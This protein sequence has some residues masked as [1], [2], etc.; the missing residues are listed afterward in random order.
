MA[1]TK[2]FISGTSYSNLPTPNSISSGPS[3]PGS[4]VVANDTDVDIN[5]SDGIGTAWSFS[6]TGMT[7]P[8]DT[9]QTTAYEPKYKVYT[10]LLT[11]SG[12]PNP[13]TITSGP[14]TI[15][16]TYEITNY[17]PGDDFTNVGASSNAN[18]IKYVATRD[19]PSVWTNSTELSYNTGVPV[20]TVLE[21]TIGNV[22]FGYDGVGSY[23]VFSPEG[24][25]LE[26]KTFAISTPNSISSGIQN[27]YITTL[28]RYTDNA[29]L[30][31]SKTQNLSNKDFELGDDLLLNTPIEIR[32][33]N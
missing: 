16:Y 25:F 20:V 12:G 8:D 1:T 7:F 32:V 6:P 4:A 14:L 21:N 24:V 3:A 23:Y 2:Y 10:A 28:D 27:F 17:Q 15:G 13:Q 5:F 18:G 30:I 29:V 9:V 19:T 26:N 31:L 22:W 11:Q 33:Y